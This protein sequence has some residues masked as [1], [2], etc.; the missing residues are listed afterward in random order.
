M[1]CRIWMS[2]RDYST[3]GCVTE[4]VGA[5]CSSL[6]WLHRGIVI[7]CHRIPL[8]TWTQTQMKSSNTRSSKGYSLEWFFE[9]KSLI[10]CD[11]LA[12]WPTQRTNVP[13]IKVYFKIKLASFSS[14]KSN[15]NIARS[16]SFREFMPSFRSCFELFTLSN[17]VTLNDFVPIY[18][19]WTHT[20][21]HRENTPS[22][23]CL[24]PEL[25]W[26]NSSLCLNPG[27][28]ELESQKCRQ[29]W[30]LRVDNYFC[31]HS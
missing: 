27:L 6:P 14:I 16:R 24:R 13:L 9:W 29:S 12:Y 7:G 10:V 2:H 15:R 3:S 18:T 21:S 31:L 28:R 5:S 22:S 4:F 17:H 1:G 23:F 30:K 19:V 8:E 20:H 26:S 25:N 11:W